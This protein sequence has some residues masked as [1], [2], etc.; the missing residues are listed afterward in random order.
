MTEWIQ[1]HRRECR[2]ATGPSGLSLRSWG[3]GRR[4]AEHH[5]RC[6]HAADCLQLTGSEISGAIEHEHRLVH[7]EKLR[8]RGLTGGNAKK[9][10]RR[11]GPGDLR[12]LRWHR[13]TTSLRFRLDPSVPLRTDRDAAPG[14]GRDG[15]PDIQNSYAV[16]PDQEIVDTAHDCAGKR[17]GYHAPV[18]VRV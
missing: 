13:I 18:V 17:S 7:P 11:V 4:C 5:L 2:C 3:L 12:T 15:L 1:Q 16:R 6:Q 14:S 10:T 9:R 8:V